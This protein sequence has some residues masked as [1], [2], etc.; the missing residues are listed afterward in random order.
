MAVALSDSLLLNN[1]IVLATL[2]IETF[3]TFLRGNATPLMPLD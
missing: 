2:Y 3:L 1:D